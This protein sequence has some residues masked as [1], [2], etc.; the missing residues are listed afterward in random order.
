[1]KI[2]VAGAG[3]IG[4]SIASELSKEKHDITVIERSVS[5]CQEV[6][7]TLDVFTLNGNAAA[8]GILEEA[9][10]PTAD[11]LIAVTQADETNLMIC[12]TAKKL[13]VKHTIAQ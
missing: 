3:R 5:V 12:L 1:M 2:I 10:A 7:D 4:Y 6:D 11:L 13:G 9:G 8:C